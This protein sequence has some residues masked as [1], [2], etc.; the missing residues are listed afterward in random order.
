MI[1]LEILVWAGALGFGVAY[2]EETLIAL[3]AI[4]AGVAE[5]LGQRRLRSEVAE[6]RSE[7]AGVR[8]EVASV[9]TAQQYL[10]RGRDLPDRVL[11]LEIDVRRLAAESDARDE[12]EAEDAEGEDS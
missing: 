11:A 10:D 3:G 7:L 12:A 9:A 1:D 2:F 4:A 5:V 8:V 6:L